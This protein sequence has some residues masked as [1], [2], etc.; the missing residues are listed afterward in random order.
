MRAPRPSASIAPAP[1]SSLW[2]SKR[3]V[4]SAGAR[5]GREHRADARAEL[6][7]ARRGIGQRAARAHRRAGAAAD[8]QVR[9]DDDAAAAGPALGLRVA[10]DRRRR[11]DVDA[12]GAADLAVARVGADLLLVVEELRLLELAGAVA[13]AQH[14]GEQRGVVG[15]VEVALRRLVQRDLRHRLQ[16]EDEIEA[17]ALLFGGALEVD[18]GR[19]RRRRARSRDGRCTW[20]GRSGS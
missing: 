2:I 15:G 10:A 18:R 9:L 14:G 4:A 20:R 17:L 11:A 19:R 6:V 1:A 8:A 16:V 7:R 12:R 13:Q 5:I 3:S